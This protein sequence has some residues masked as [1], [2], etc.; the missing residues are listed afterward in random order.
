[1]KRFG[2]EACL[3]SFPVMV[4]RQVAYAPLTDVDLGY[5]INLEGMHDCPGKGI[6]KPIIDEPIVLSLYVDLNR[7]S[8]KIYKEFKEKIL[9]WKQMLKVDD[10]K[11]RR[12]RIPEYK[13]YLRIYDL[14]TKKGLSSKKIA[15]KQYGDDEIDSVRKVDRHISKCRKLIKG[16]YRHLDI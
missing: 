2:F 3:K 1:L 16:G 8:T 15:L 6:N 5:E 10:R 4:V 13:K 11:R 14:K 9:K 7:P 12:N